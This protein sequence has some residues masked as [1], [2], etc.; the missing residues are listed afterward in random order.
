MKVQVQRTTKIDQKTNQKYVLK[1]KQMDV[2][3]IRKN[4]TLIANQC[5][6][7]VFR[8]YYICKDQEIKKKL[9]FYIL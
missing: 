2:I 8:M 5:N 6:I 4:N 9:N 7:L 1:K 3:N